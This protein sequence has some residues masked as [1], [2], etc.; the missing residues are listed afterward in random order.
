MRNVKV[1]L[2]LPKDL[3]H[4]LDPSGTEL[5]RRVLEL[6]LVRLFQDDVI[7]SGKAA[8]LLGVP[9]AEFRRI[10]HERGIPW[11]NITPEELLEDIR[12]STS[13]EIQ[14]PA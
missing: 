14:Q 3:A 12:S 5:D 4:L 9:K 11:V 1:H 2:E 8:E 7:S 13:A 10:L 6:V